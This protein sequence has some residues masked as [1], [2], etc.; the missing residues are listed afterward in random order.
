MSPA[1]HDRERSPRSIPI[2]VED[3]Q[4][5]EEPEPSDETSH[6]A[7]ESSELD[8]LER[9]NEVLRRRVA[10]LVRDVERAE[11]RSQK[12]ASVAQKAERVR[13]LGDLGG[14]L[15]SVE[16]ALESGVERGPW[17]AGLEAIRTQLLK[18]IE[19]QGARLTGHPGERVDP[20]IHEAIARV[21][22]SQQ[23]GTIVE[24]YRHGICL[25]DGT[26]VRNAQVVVAAP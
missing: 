1:D 23:A 3:R 2:S 24:V 15:D 7:E 17:R 11:G 16:R 12:S 10:E 4:S 20:N 18:Y 25:D 8:R 9:E 22:S 19:A 21:R 14:V 26:P 6:D 13:M 5:G